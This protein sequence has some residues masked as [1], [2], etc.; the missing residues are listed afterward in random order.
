MPGP[1]RP[2]LWRHRGF[3]LLWAGQAVRQVGSQV[4][5]LALA[6][7][8]IV[9]LHATAFGAGLLSAAVTGACLLIALPAGVVADRVAKRTLRLASDAAQIVV[10]GSVPVACAAGVLTLGQLH[11]VA[12]W[13]PARSRCSSWS[14]APATCRRWSARSS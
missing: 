1:V 14:P 7:A 9:V 8:A 6:L 12:L 10:I 5:V 4:T 11:M 13:S 3:V 2:V